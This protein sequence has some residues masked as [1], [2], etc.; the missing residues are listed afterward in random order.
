[1]NALPRRF[2]VETIIFLCIFAFFVYLIFGWVLEFA[3]TNCRE[4]FSSNTK[5][6]YIPNK[7]VLNENIEFGVSDLED[8]AKSVCDFLKLDNKLIIIDPSSAD[9]SAT[10]MD[11]DYTKSRSELDIDKMYKNLSSDA[12]LEKAMDAVYGRLFDV[13]MMRDYTNEEIKK[14]W[15]SINERQP[16]DLKL[17][18]LIAIYTASPSASIAPGK[19]YDYF[20]Q[21]LQK[22]NTNATSLAQ[23]RKTLYAILKPRYMQNQLTSAYMEN[24]LRLQNKD[25]SEK[26]KSNNSIVYVLNTCAELGATE[27]DL[28]FSDGTYFPILEEQRDLFSVDKIRLYQ[29]SSRLIGLKE[30]VEKMQEHKDAKIKELLSTDIPRFVSGFAKYLAKKGQTTPSVCI[31]MLKHPVI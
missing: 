19:S 23:L 31:Y 17:Y 7:D 24:A 20:L 16:S 18:D 5:F 8:E 11:G 13:Q 21:L 15:D 4:A 6:K 2:R 29:C 27:K 30:F 22:Y 25:E 26:P 14:L 3:L 1:M 9:I 28:E 10:V 12:Q